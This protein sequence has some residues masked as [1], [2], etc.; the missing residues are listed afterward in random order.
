MFNS[1]NKEVTFSI[2]ASHLTGIPS[3]GN[4]YLGDKA[5]EYYNEKNVNDFVQIPWD[6]ISHISASV[7]LGKK[8]NRFAIFTKSNGHFTFS[9]RNNKKTLKSMGNYFPVEKMYRSQSLVS[10]FKKKIKNL[11]RSNK[12]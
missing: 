7:I 6:Q 12:K 10:F 5:F 9:T 3:Y 4:V 8:I 11:F 2:K 1:Q